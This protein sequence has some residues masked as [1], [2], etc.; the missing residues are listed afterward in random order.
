MQQMSAQIQAAKIQVLENITQVQAAQI[1]QANCVIQAMADA[2]T[3]GADGEQVHKHECY[4][5]GL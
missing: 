4:I 2:L 1:Q 5:Q 3:T